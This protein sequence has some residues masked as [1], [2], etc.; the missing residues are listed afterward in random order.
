MPS[1]SIDPIVCSASIIQNIQSIV[2]RIQSKETLVITW[3]LLI[4][5]KQIML[6]KTAKQQE[7]LD[8][9]IMK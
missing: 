5:E 6:P 3:P 4:P 1:N 7:Q 8:I 9:M 2:S